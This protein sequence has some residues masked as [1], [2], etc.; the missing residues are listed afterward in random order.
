MNKADNLLETNINEIYDELPVGIA[1][2]DSDGRVTDCNE[3]YLEIL[4]VSRDDILG[5]NIF[6]SYNFTEEVMDTIRSSDSYS[7]DVLYTVPKDV[8]TNTSADTIS[9]S[10]KIVRRHENGLTKGYIIYLTNHTSEWKKYETQLNAQDRRYRALVDNL[11]LDYTHTKLIFD[12]SGQIVDYLN[13]SGNKHCEE[14]YIKHNMTWGA[15]LASK[16]L[17]QTG[18]VI[19]DKL[20]ELKNSGATGGH[21]IYEATEVGEIYDMVV[22]FEEDEWVNL[23]SIPVTTL[24][25]AKRKAEK[26]LKEELRSKQEAEAEYNKMREEQLAIFDA[27]ADNYANVYIVDT[28]EETLRV[29]KLNGYITTGVNS[30]VATVYPYAVVKNQYVSERVL[31]EEQDMMM[32]AL[33]L[34]SVKRA[35][36]DSDEYA[37]NYRVLSNGETHYYQYKYIKLRNFG[38]IIAGFQNVDDIIEEQ[39]KYQTQLSE[40]LSAAQ[41]A[42]RAKS[43]FL[44]NM[45][46][47]IRTPMNAIIGFTALAQ[48]HITDQVQ[49]QD[50]L[51]KINTSS[52]HL[53]ELINDILDM[54][55]IESGMVKL[56][57]KAVCMT[58]IIHDLQTMTQGLADAKNINLVIDMQDIIHENVF[59]DKLRLNQVMLNIVSNAIKFT[60]T[61]GNVAIR[62]IEL[63]C[64]TSCYASYEFSVKD[65]GI[66]MSQ[67]FIGHIFDTFTRE[68]SSTVSGIQGT[69]LGMAITKNIIDMM[70]GDIRV[71]SEEGKGSLFTVSLNLRLTDGSLESGQMESEE[72]AND[73]IV[74]SRQINRKRDYSGKRALLVEDN[75]LN[76]EIAMAILEETGMDVDSVCDGDEAV[77]AIDNEPADRYDIILMDIQMPRM[78]GYTATRA[79]RALADDKK[80]NIPIVAMTANAFE[81]DRKKAFASGMNEHI[82]KPVSMDAIVTVLDE[83]FIGE[84]V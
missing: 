37:G 3:F 45:S 76:R 69:G 25:Q 49:V 1:L 12:E 2:C 78:D 72:V 35:L 40:A 56:E 75:E 53:L 5:Y 32:D 65:N 73:N 47:D 11:P 28:A 82:I 27:L 23:L 29:L 18:H 81:E 66:G 9:I 44:N 74:M 52:E 42:S 10:V 46:H 26:E 36:M 15:T 50:Y 83:I 55:R 79:I 57:E 13:M 8:F 48:S 38:Y 7:Y 43:T 60:Q 67:E 16:F 24:E 63:P 70:G 34:D 71:E 59:V 68:Y 21:F 54:S 64:R 4:G 19:I 51:S 58:D 62:L 6:S 41:Q 77:S 84:N 39:Q 31:P 80:S 30:D 17:S 14:F 61:G 20:N 22:V 33:E